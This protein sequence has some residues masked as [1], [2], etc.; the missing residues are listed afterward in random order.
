MLQ[1][2]ILQLYEKRDS[3]TGEC[4]FREIFKNTSST[5]QL[6]ATTSAT[7]VIGIEYYL[8]VKMDSYTWGTLNVYIYST[9]LIF[10]K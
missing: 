1:T 3:S 4:E 8:H 2:F 5:E 9:V 6:Q 10:G 7:G